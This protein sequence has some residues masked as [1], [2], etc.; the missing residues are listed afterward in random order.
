VY[1]ASKE[2][3]IFAVP[4]N[5][6]KAAWRDAHSILTIPPPQSDEQRP[7]CFNLLARAHS[8]NVVPPKERFVTQVVGLASAPKKA[9]KFLLWR[10]ERM[11]V[12][13]A[14]VGDLNLIER[15]GGL[16]QN[17]EQA[18]VVL[19]NRVRRMAKLYLSPGSELPAGQQPDKDEV[20]KVSD[21][22]DPR[23]AYWAWLEKHFFTLLE[24]L[25]NDWDSTNNEW[26]PDDQQTATSIWRKHVKREAQQALEESIRSLGTTARAIQA[27]ARVRTDFND[28]D[29]NPPS[30]KMTKAKGKKKGGT[31]Q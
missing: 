11:P 14:L 15:L 30:P 19:N 5:S 9:G 16:I 25:P 21:A 2:E 1:R 28:D 26:K 10:H 20:T 6:G 27:V 4:L 23:P 31:K 22:I 17:A 7:E 13:A 29:L 24:S 18:A 8:N 12:S 3:G